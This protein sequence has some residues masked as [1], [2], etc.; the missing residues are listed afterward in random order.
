ML[1]E[2]K[3]N[4][5]VPRLLAVIETPMISICLS[6]LGVRLSFIFVQ[7]QDSLGLGPLLRTNDFQREGVLPFKICIFLFDKKNCIS[8]FGIYL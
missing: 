7:V 4:A 5:S 3:S 1:Y 2:S 8:N 6:L